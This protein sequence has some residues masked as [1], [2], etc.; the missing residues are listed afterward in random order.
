VGRGGI[1]E[2]M[3]PAIHILDTNA[4]VFWGKG[5]SSTQKTIKALS[6]PQAR[7]VI[8]SYVFEEIHIDFRKRLVNQNNGAIRIP[9]SPLLRLV[10][11]C[12][13]VRILPRGAAVLAWEFRLWNE[14]N[15]RKI[16]ISNQDIPIAAAVNAVRD[17]DAWTVVLVTSDGELRRWAMQNGVDV[18]TCK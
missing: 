7:L 6:D 10:K 8:P 9:P 15:K 12:S 5:G 4:V 13:N 14:N 3:K 1:P 2:F 17:C 11:H 16:G 18:I